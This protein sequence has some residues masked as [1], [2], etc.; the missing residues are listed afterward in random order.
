M[1]MV[2]G[3][4]FPYT[5]EGKAAAAKAAKKPKAK[6]KAKAKGAMYE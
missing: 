6:G 2:K 5:K 3:K 1:P 4:K